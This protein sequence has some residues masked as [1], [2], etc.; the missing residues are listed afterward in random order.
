MSFDADRG[1]PLRQKEK[2]MRWVYMA[3]NCMSTEKKQEISRRMKEST[4][5]VSKSLA[6]E[7]KTR[8]FS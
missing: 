7:Q 5:S 1:Y 6:T 8:F 2:D 4:D 3:M